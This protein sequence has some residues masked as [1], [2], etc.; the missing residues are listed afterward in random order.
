VKPVL[1]TALLTAC[2]FHAI[3][4]SPTRQAVTSSDAG[5]GGPASWVLDFTPVDSTHA[6]QVTHG[7]TFWVAESTLGKFA[8]QAW[9]KPRG[10]DWPRYWLS[11]GYGGAHNILA[12]FTYDGTNV[13]AY[14]QISDGT[15]GGSAAN[16]TSA[17]AVSLD[18]WHHILI[19]W[20]QNYLRQRIDGVLDGKAAYSGTR[21]EPSL[22]NGGGGLFIGGSDHQNFNGRIA[23]FELWEGADPVYPNDQEM[24][25]RRRF[26]PWATLL[27]YTTIVPANLLAVYTT[28]ADVIPDLSPAG[29]NGQF[30]PGVPYAAANGGSDN[31][32]F[33]PGM[34]GFLPGSGQGHGP[35]WALDNDAP[36]AQ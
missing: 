25:I 9:V 8:V 24:Q 10:T 15:S 6:P 3:H 17:N 27:D 5:A 32:Q 16:V 20:D 36:T 30:H 12:G 33:Y 11:D 34:S 21:A 19:D 23:E 13:H 18:T 22:A 14:A 28:P 29:Y 1:F 26:L 4:T 7:S 35:M 31:G 2:Q